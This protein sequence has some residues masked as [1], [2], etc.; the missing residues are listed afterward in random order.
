MTDIW[1]FMLQT[2]N[3]TGVAVLLLVIKFLFKDKLPPKWH[4]TVWGV[5]GIIVLIPVGVGGR[6]T[7]FNWNVPIE[8]VK[9]LTG[10]YGFSKVTYPIPTVTSVPETVTEWIFAAYVLGV[11]LSLLWYTISYFRLCFVLS[12][13]SDVSEEFT[14]RV[15]TTAAKVGV[16]PCRII[17]V[18]GLH[19]AFVFG[20]LRPVL[21]VP[22]GVEVD[23]KVLLHEMYHLKSRDTLW[24]A[25]ICVLRSLHWCNPMM[26]YCAGKAL[27]DL[28][29]RCDQYVLE[30]L[31]GEERR[32]YG[33]ILLSMVNERFAKTPGATCVNNGGK[34]IRERIE[35]IA[36]FKLYPVGMGLASYCILIVLTVSLILGVKATP[37]SVNDGPLWLSVASA[38][39]TYCTTYAG[40]FDTYA[41]AV[42]TENGFYRIMCTP[43]SEQKAIIKEVSENAKAGKYELWDS[44]LE[45]MPYAHEGYYIYNLTKTGDNC[46]EGLLVTRVA[47]V[48]D[49]IPSG[50]DKIYLG[51]QN[52][53]VVK[54]GMRWCVT[55]MDDFSIVG[56]ISDYMGWGCGEL[57]G[58]RYTGRISDFEIDFTTQ[59]IRTVNNT[60]SNEGDWGL[61]FGGAT[62]FDTVPRPDANFDTGAMYNISGVTHLGTEDERELINCL[63]I[64]LEAVFE[65]EDRPEELKVPEPNSVVS[66]N[67]S[68]FYGSRNTEPGWGPYVKFHSS[69]FTQSSNM[70]DLA[71]PEFLVADLYVNGEY[72]GQIELYTDGGDAG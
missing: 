41:K 20:L 45:E 25:V 30:F 58:V 19:G 3:A 16:K 31:E 34:R 61:I 71:I 37:S 7:L 10:E 70:D 49:E 68:K 55:P 51:V 35:A 8:A 15:H 50:P 56:S 4:F 32:E 62:S 21:A 44:G 29:A 53:R 11:I 6:Y 26:G 46:Y 14:E 72:V 69:G 5:L 22:E 17:A 9:G 38:R 64:S 60:V 52:L 18:K 42:L 43:E 36:R 1:G 33:H 24:S 63:G 23:D 40:A 28:E 12:K 66:S 57:P 2:L 47:Y 13:G 39:S 27:N 54:E 48:P 65:G 67:G 59:A